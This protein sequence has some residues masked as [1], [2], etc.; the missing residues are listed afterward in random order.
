MIDISLP[1]LTNFNLLDG[2]ITLALLGLCSIVSWIITIERFIYF[3]VNS[4]NPHTTVRNF[5]QKHKQQK[6]NKKRSQLPLDKPFFSKASAKA[7]EYVLE[8]CMS[9]CSKKHNKDLSYFDEI[10]SRALAQ[11]IPEIQRY[12]GI[13]ATLSTISP[14]IG[15]LGTV[16]G[17]IR[18]FS[19]LG[20][21]P[22]ASS[23]YTHELNAGISQALI[24]TAAGLLVAIPATISYNYY[25]L[26][27]ETMLRDMEIAAA[28]LKSHILNYVKLI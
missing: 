5:L 17:I 1:S 4:Q 14:Y 2:G 11:K 28:Y 20:M 15:L 9:A 19:S 7:T 24:A 25:R 18:A 23:S 12:L 22:E 27:M 6:A 16:F 26:R 21:Q 13:Q 8:E 3:Q 10:K